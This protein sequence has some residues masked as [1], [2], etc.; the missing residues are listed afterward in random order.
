MASSWA[1]CN[2]E[3]SGASAATQQNR[4]PPPNAMTGPSGTPRPA[5]RWV[6]RSANAA[7]RARGSWWTAHWVSV[8]CGNDPAPSRCSASAGSRVAASSQAAWIV[9][10][11]GSTTS[12]MKPERLSLTWEVIVLLIQLGTLRAVRRTSEA[13]RGGRTAA[14]AFGP[15][16]RHWRLARRLSQLALATA[17]DLAARRLCFLETGRAHPSR[18]MVQLLASVLDIPLG[19]RNTLLLGAGYAPA[20]GERK[21]DASELA[22]VRRALSFVLRQQEPFPAIVV[23]GGWNIVMRN[24]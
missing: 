9:A 1:C 11:S 6:R 7:I 10:A 19:E 5:S 17:A 4:K 8:R 3:R 21:L 14:P 15:L 16:L 22:H 18:E 2:S 23:D 24:E 20:Y 13:R 12:P